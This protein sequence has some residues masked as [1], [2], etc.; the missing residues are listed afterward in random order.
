MS[1]DARGR[2]SVGPSQFSIWFWRC[3]VAVWFLLGV[4]FGLERKWDYFAL[5]VLW[6]LAAVA[7]WSRGEKQLHL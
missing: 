1:V 7:G 3:A 2:S 5:S 4:G 6:V